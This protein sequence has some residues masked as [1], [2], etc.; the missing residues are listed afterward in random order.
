MAFDA[1]CFLVTN[2]ISFKGMSLRKLARSVQ[3]QHPM[4]Q[5]AR[6]GCSVGSVMAPAHASSV[7]RSAAL[8]LKARQESGRCAEQNKPTQHW[9]GE[10]SEKAASDASHGPV[11][12]PERGNEVWFLS[13]TNTRSH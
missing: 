6:C 3:P 2:S 8:A 1:S 5:A 7:R 12:G 11:K 9:R 13:W 4:A 10:M